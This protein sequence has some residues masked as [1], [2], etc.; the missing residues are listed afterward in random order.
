M[1]IL[2][3]K[4]KLENLYLIFLPYDLLQKHGV[5]VGLNR[6]NVQTI[7]TISFLLQEYVAFFLSFLHTSVTSSFYHYRWILFVHDNQLGYLLYTREL[8]QHSRVDLRPIPV[9]CFMLI[10]YSHNSNS[11]DK[12]YQ[13]RCFIFGQW[14]KLIQ[15]FCYIISL[16]LYIIK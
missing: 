16:F 9:L 13:L 8:D 5:Y 7:W 12:L 6:F 1:I 3:T 10:H 4:E 15:P 14:I 2:V 11:L